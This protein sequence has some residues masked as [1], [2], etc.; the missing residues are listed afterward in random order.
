M[1][2]NDL[3]FINDL[4]R[5]ALKRGIGAQ[6]EALIALR[7]WTD[8]Q[9]YGSAP[10]IVIPAD[11]HGATPSDTASNPVPPVTICG[12]TRA[13]PLSPVVSHPPCGSGTLAEQADQKS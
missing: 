10:S 8:S 13:T 5:H 6:E 7:M 9:L 4:C 2:R 12:F 3:T 1:N 11:F